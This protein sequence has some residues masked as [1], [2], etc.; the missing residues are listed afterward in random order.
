VAGGVFSPAGA[1]TGNQSPEFFSTVTE[2]LAT[3]TISDANRAWFAEHGPDFLLSR[4]KVPTL[5]IQGTVDTLFTLDEA[6]ANFRALEKQGI[7]LKMMF[8]CGGHGV[9]MTESDSVS[10]L[11]GDS[12]LAQ[13]RRLEWFDRYLRDRRKVDTGPAFEWIDELG[14]FHTSERYPPQASGSLIGTGSGTLALTPGVSPPP[15]SGLAL[16]GT[17]QDVSVKAPVDAPAGLE[18][19]GK[20][21]LQLTYSGTGAPAE[22]HVFAQ[23]VDRSRDVV[24]GNQVTPIPVT[25]DGAEHQL[26]VPLEGIASLSAEPGYELQIVAGS[27]VY[28]IQRSAG[29]VEIHEARVEL[30]VTQ[31]HTTPADGCL[32]YPFGTKAADR[33]RGSEGRD[34]LRGRSGDDRING[35]GGNDTINGGRGKDRIKGGDGDDVIRAAR[36]ARDRINC[37][38]GDDRALVHPKRDRWRGCEKVVKRG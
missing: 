15:G 29:A 26:T 30:P 27:T 21:Q 37:G 12:E 18:I 13:Q 24:V 7:P 33:L 16:Y 1:Q 5:I 23:L 4:I 22:T 28:D 9:C 32:S 31:P 19:V 2:G 25:L 35:F 10:P 20:P 8:F 6:D 11:F 34:C 36:G 14:A 17:P 38:P 3:G